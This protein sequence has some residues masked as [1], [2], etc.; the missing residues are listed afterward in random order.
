MGNVKKGDK[1]RIVKPSLY[2]PYKVGDV[3]NVKKVYNCGDVE[4]VEGY[5]IWSHEY[6]V[7]END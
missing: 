4:T 3:L 2:S 5:G 7:L 6:E 1:I